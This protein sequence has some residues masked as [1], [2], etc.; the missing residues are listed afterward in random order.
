MLDL[1][2][3]E[4]VAVRDG[5]L[6]QLLEGDQGVDAVK[7]HAT[8]IADDA[9]TAVSIRQTS[10]D[11]VVAGALDTGGVN[12][13]DAIVMG[14]AITGEYLLDLGIRLLASLADGL[15]NHAPTAVGHHGALAGD[16]GLQ[17]DDHIILVIDIASGEGV[18]VRGSMGVDVI[19]ALLAFHGQIF[20]IQLFPQ[21]LG[22]LGRGG[23]EGFITL[24]R[25]VVLLD[26][27]THINVLFPVAAGEALPSL[28]L[29]FLSGND[30]LFCGS[31]MHSF[32]CLVPY[33]AS[34]RRINPF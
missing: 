26:E 13:E 24:I 6:V 25:R 10:E 14:L 22:L 8:V 34:M 30:W 33:D 31:H 5:V 20:V 17:A 18:D 12:A 28:S 29:E 2:L 1:R 19:N 16:V 4:V 23:Q 21:V 11:L 9:A 3:G 32:L 15:L 27:V 7:G